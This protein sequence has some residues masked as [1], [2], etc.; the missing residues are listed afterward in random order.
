[1]QRKRVTRISTLPGYLLA[2][3]LILSCIAP[4]PAFAAGYVCTGPFGSTATGDAATA[5]GYHNKANGDYSSAF[6]YYNEAD[7]KL[8]LASGSHAIASGES[9]IAVGTWR[10]RNGSGFVDP[11]EQTTASGFAASAFG[12][13]AQA[14]GDESAALGAET[15]ATGT[16]SVAL[17]SD[18]IADRAYTVSVGSAG[19]ERQ[20]VNVAA[21]TMDTDAAN[22]SQLYALSDALGGGASY[23]GG[24]FT[25]PT[26][27][28]QGGTYHD[29]G[30]AFGAVNTSL[31]NL[32]SKIGAAGGIQGPPGPQGPTGPQGA[33]G[34]A[35]GGPNEVTY[36][37]SSHAT[38]TLSGTG[39]GTRIANVA[40][41][42]GAS[43]AVNKGQLD[44]QTQQALQSA[45]TYTDA[46]SSQTL[47]AAN[48]YTDQQIA[49]AFGADL[50]QFEAQTNA[51][52]NQQDKR[53]DT[54]G[55]MGAASAQ[56]AVNT[57]G[58]S[59]DNRIGV[60]AGSYSGQT[61]ARSA[62][63]TCSPITKR[64][65]RSVR[66]SPAAKIPAARAQASVG[67]DTQGEDCARLPLCR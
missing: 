38:L 11:D 67:E 40:N 37:N 14:I 53:I 17:G 3:A 56:M 28:I 50:S 20:I 54:L 10:D 22:L 5:C 1:M 61:A 32:Y 57:G 15:K 44:S 48:A 45:K 39:G 4:L 19:Q 24:V 41:G 47:N 35:G 21:A 34:V 33:A 63:S 49:G 52:F 27:T 18:S 2:L 9:S 43:D 13:A 30:S 31:T 6:G 46:S 62:T 25:A 23:A 16:A 36:D 59:G 64:A 58:L 12:A 51:R 66:R 29:V 26:Y 8:S 7:G 55:A 60:G 42:T 65:S